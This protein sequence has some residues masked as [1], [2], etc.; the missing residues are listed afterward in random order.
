MPTTPTRSGP[1]IP[2]RTPFRDVAKRS[3][4]AGGLGSVGEQAATAIADFV[5]VDM[6]AELLH[7]REDA[8]GRD[9]DGAKR[10]NAVLPAACAPHELPSRRDDGR[11]DIARLRRQ[12]MRL[13]GSRAFP[14]SQR[15]RAGTAC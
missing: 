15:L 9:R 13:A 8:E 2:K 10:A 6:F 4:T 11:R 1:R 12:P 5:V 14:T 3:L 7:R